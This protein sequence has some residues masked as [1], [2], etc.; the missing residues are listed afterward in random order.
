[1]QGPFAPFWNDLSTF[2]PGI[3]WVPGMPGN[4][5]RPGGPYNMTLK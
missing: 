2:S 4:P 1:M 3:P 5:S